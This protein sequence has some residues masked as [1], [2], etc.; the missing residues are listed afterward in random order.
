MR[1]MNVAVVD[2]GS[3]TIR[4]LVGA[5]A[6]GRMVEVAAGRRVVGLGADVE[7]VGAI[8]VPK[9]AETVECV[10]GFVDEAR[11]ADAEL[12]EV[13]VA[14][15]GRQARNSAQLIHLLSRATELEARVLTREE[16]ARLA[17]EGA[18]A[19]AV[20][21]GA[22]AVC[23]VG[24]GSTQVAVGSV[25]HGPVWLRSIDLGS[26]RLSARILHSDPP[27]KKEVAALRSEARAA[28]AALTPPVPGGAVAVGGTARALRKLV[29]PSLGPGELRHAFDLLRRT[30]AAELG[31]RFGIASWR[32]RALPAGTAIVASLQSLLGVPLDVGRGGLREGV[33]LDLLDR[34]PLP[35][36]QAGGR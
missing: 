14:S 7:R 8:S 20:R 25:E 1:P 5:R 21:R 19:G 13:V 29:G 12:I 30:P 27:G 17:F 4:L 11:C 24:G 22:V 2:V 33:V 15:P 35:A 16:E 6:D 32:A 36:V 28:V 34:L 31:R 23:D 18:L 10:A 9:L 3:N 26:L